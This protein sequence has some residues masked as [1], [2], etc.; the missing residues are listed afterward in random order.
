MRRWWQGPAA[1]ASQP[2]LS[3]SCS[4]AHGGK[5]S[6][7]LANIALVT[8]LLQPC[9][10]ALEKGA[11]SSCFQKKAA[12]LAGE[13][14]ATSCF[15]LGLSLWGHLKRRKQTL[16]PP[17]EGKWTVLVHPS[18]IHDSYKPQRDCCG[19]SAQMFSEGLIYHS[20]YHIVIK[21]C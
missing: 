16:C 21:E 6:A 2:C 11:V 18:L 4:G 5:W 13:K 10:S 8:V 14:M 9:S 7:G 3:V 12:L 20:H 1:L 15:H 17:L 19:T